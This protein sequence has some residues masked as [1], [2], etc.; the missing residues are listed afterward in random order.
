VN[1][2]KSRT[3]ILQAA[4]HHIALFGE[5]RFSMSGV[6][7]AAGLSRGT[8]YRYFPNRE[9]LLEGIAEHVRQ[10]FESGVESAAAE[11]GSPRVKIERIVMGRVDTETMEA[12]R[13]LRELQPAFTLEFLTAHLSG[14]VLVYRNA[15][16]D[17]FD[18]SD[19]AMSCDDFTDIMARLGASGTL[20]GDSTETT[21]R[22]IVA[23][24]DAIQ[25]KGSKSRARRQPPL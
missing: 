11:G 3:R 14:F 12:I 13:R 9:E 23:I 4:L 15:L 17:L 16:A 18:R 8:V 20:F 25:P 6:A 1:D 22:L 5:G 2:S 19:L 24:W 21:N 7:D 10:S